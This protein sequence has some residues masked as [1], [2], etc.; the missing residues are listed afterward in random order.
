MLQPEPVGLLGQSALSFMLFIYAMQQS[1]SPILIT[2]RGLA[3]PRPPEQSSTFQACNP[4]AFGK[5]GK[6]KDGR[7]GGWGEKRRETAAVGEYR[8]S[9]IL[10]C[11]N[12]PT[13][14]D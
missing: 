12:S 9:S 5:G 10:M 14:A 1:N 11:A 7:G 13:P 6:R 2:L 8:S 3:I 4:R